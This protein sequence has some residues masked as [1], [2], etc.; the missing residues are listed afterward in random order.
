MELQQALNI[1]K[2]NGNDPDSLKKAYRQACLK[3][4]PDHNPNG[5]EMMKLIN[6][7]YDFLKKHLHKWNFNDVNND[8]PI[9][10][11]LQELFDKIKHFVNIK[12]E[13]C[14]TWLWLSGE[15]WRYKK[16]LKE[17]GFKWASKKRQ[18]YWSPPGYRKRTKKV[19]SMDEIRSKYGSVEL[20]PEL[21]SAIG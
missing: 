3:Y 15:T 13:V 16:Q 12:A 7:A 1:L 10:E 5:L 4:H 19:F 8:T 11:V 2:P 18:W 14:G 6:C 21:R 9:D 20:E 17:Y